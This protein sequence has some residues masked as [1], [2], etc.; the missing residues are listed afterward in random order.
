MTDPE[1]GCYAVTFN[2]NLSS[3]EAGWGARGIFTPVISSLYH[4]F[5]SNVQI[6]QSVILHTHYPTLMFR[7]FRLL[8][9]TRETQFADDICSKDVNPV[10]SIIS[11]QRL[12]RE[13]DSFILG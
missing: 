6:F 9:L 13:K 8:P 7:R 11:G 2:L 5:T 10:S 1:I 4:T 12:I 3:S